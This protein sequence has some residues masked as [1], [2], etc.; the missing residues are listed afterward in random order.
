LENMRDLDLQKSE[1][2]EE[3][4]K[5]AKAEEKSLSFEEKK[6]LDKQHR[7]LQQQRDAL[8]AQVADCD[9]RLAQMDADLVVDASLAT[10]EFFER[11]TALK[12]EQEELMHKWE[13]LL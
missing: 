10:A 8:E 6:E 9:Q 12:K 4:K 3:Q 1:K 7:K 11:Y 13:E 5:K 2:K